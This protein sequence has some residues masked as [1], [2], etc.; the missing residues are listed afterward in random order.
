MSKKTDL[1][2]YIKD[3]KTFY[4]LEYGENYVGNTL[5]RVRKALTQRS[6]IMPSINSYN[7]PQNYE[8]MSLKEA[9][10]A[11]LETKP[12]YIS[13]HVQKLLETKSSNFTEGN[14]K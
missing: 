1:G 5:D 11:S 12:I 10:D 4:Y 14:F 6:L 13:K 7:K 8:I 2:I 3:T 9:I